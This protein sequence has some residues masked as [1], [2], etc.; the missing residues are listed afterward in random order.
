MGNTF[1]QTNDRQIFGI[2]FLKIQTC[3]EDEIWFM[4]VFWHAQSVE[5]FLTWNSNRKAANWGH[6][7][8]PVEFSPI[9]RHGLLSSRL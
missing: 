1:A 9:F 2:L 4:G 8:F 5:I 6:C 7:F 3:L